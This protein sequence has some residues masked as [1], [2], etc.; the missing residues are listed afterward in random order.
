[1]IEFNPTVSGASKVVRAELYSRG[2]GVGEVAA[3]YDVDVA[4][5]LWIVKAKGLAEFPARDMGDPPAYVEK[6]FVALTE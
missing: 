4:A 5:I 6:A 2:L 1:M 3:K